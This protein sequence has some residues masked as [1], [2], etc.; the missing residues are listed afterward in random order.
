MEFPPTLS[1]EQD[2][3]GSFPSCQIVEEYAEH[4]NSVS[5]SSSHHACALERLLLERGEK[6]VSLTALFRG[7]RQK[8][9]LGSRHQEMGPDLRQSV[10]DSMKAGLRC[11]CSKAWNESWSDENPL[12]TAEIQ[13]FGAPYFSLSKLVLCGV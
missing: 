2:V 8:K 3:A 10:P 1:A 12:V 4:R 5:P 11:Q 7:R 9:S 13:H 6:V